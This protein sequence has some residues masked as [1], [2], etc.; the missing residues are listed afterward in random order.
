MSDREKLLGHAKAHM[1]AHY[2]HSDVAR[3]G[4][5]QNEIA[6]RLAPPDAPE[7]IAQRG[8]KRAQG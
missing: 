7:S 2:T 5:F 8:A 3:R 4:R 6:M 1:T